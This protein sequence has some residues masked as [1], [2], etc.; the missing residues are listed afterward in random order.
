MNGAEI[1]RGLLVADVLGMFALAAL[2]LGHRR[3]AWHQYL[4][5]GLVA[6]IFPVFGPFVVI[7]S[8][9]G[10]VR[11][12]ASIRRIYAADTKDRTQ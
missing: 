12:R 2:Y 6:L 8:H 7:A 1:L 11:R 4:G 3:L 9:P 10:A 5:W